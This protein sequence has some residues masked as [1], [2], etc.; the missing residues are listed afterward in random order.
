MPP[1]FAWIRTATTVLAGA[2]IATAGSAQAASALT[3]D[4]IVARHLE[5]RGGKERILAAQAVR[6]TGRMLLGPGTEAPFT[7]EWKGPDR[8]RLEFTIGGQTGV[9]AFD[10]ATAWAHL[11]FAG[12]AEPEALPA[13]RTADMRQQADFAGP[14]VDYQAKG[15]QVALVGKR[16][17]EGS[18]AYD[19]EITLA[20]GD[21]LH[22]LLDTATF[23]TVRQ[24]TRRT[25]GGQEIA[26]ETSIGDYQTIDGLV[27][28]QRIETRVVGAPAN[29]PAQKTTIE[30]YDFRAA[31][32]DARFTFPGPAATTN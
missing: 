30:T 4:E 28:P 7:M 6:I 10:G 24:E 17:L 1:K 8:M 32:D 27:V 26:F 11:P 5:A 22:E 3:A 18:E 15:H 14:L 20:S 31:I 16:Q 23:L 2:L 21:V 9:Q 29:A 19:L 12:R 13:E 25:Q